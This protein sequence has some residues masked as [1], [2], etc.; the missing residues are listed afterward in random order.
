MTGE[1][2]TQTGTT[3]TEKVKPTMNGYINNEGIL[4]ASVS[5]I[6]DSNYD[7]DMD[8]YSFLVRTNSG[9]FIN[10]M[11]KERQIKEMSLFV[12]REQAEQ[13]YFKHIQDNF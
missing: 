2:Q 6:E 10:V 12:S 8:K 4:F 13:R 1:T 3:I 9:D 5:E 11:L 7:V